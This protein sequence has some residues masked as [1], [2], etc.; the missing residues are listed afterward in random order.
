MVLPRQSLSFHK[1][2]LVR[3]VMLSDHPGKPNSLF[4][5][6]A[7]SMPM[8]STTVTSYEN[9]GNVVVGGSFTKRF[10]LAAFS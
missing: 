6:V 2:E 3:T 5:V 1:I 8:T 4:P 9:F 10:R 7:V